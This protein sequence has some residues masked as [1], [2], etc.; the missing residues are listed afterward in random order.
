MLS[1]PGCWHDTT[2]Q[3][4]REKLYKQQ[5]KSQEGDTHY[6]YRRMTSDRRKKSKGIS[7]RE[8]FR[9]RR[10]QAE[11]EVVVLAPPYPAESFLWGEGQAG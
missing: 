2:K 1:H 6:T 9:A 3:R 10:T 5:S 4:A 7:E 11:F 8:E